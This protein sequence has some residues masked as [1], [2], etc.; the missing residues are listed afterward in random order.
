MSEY[1]TYEFSGS[2]MCF[3]RCID[4]YWTA[5]TQAPSERKAYSNLTYRYKKENNLAS[6]SKITLLGTLT[7]IEKG[8]N[9]YEYEQ[10]S[11]EF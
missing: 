3:G 10:L 6:T 1:H 4:H 2:V 8:E 5:F 9:K 7:M 11:F